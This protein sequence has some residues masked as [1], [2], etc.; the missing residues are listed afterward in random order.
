MTLKILVDQIDTSVKPAVF[1]VLTCECDIKEALSCVYPGLQSAPVSTQPTSTFCQCNSAG[2]LGP[3]A[4]Y[5]ETP[6][7]DRDRHRLENG[8]LLH[9]VT[10]SPL[11]QQQLLA[12]AHN[13]SEVSAEIGSRTFC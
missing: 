9:S 4:V 7:Q 2:V 8:G 3:R 12:V 5:S 13:N 10:H 1:C 11:A 6:T